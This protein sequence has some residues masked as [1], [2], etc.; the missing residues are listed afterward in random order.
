[1][2]SLYAGLGR[3]SKPPG[4]VTG[5]IPRPDHPVPDGAPGFSRIPLLGIYSAAMD[6]VGSPAATSARRR[7][8]RLLFLLTVLAVGLLVVGIGSLGYAFF[9]IRG[10]AALP[11]PGATPW[12]GLDPARIVAGPAL[13]TLAGRDP[14]Q[15]YRLTLAAGE[16]D[17]A[18]AEAI[19]AAAMADGQRI[20]WLTVLARRYALTGRRQQAAM[21]YQL[22]GDLALLAPNLGDRARVEALLAV[23]EGWILLQEPTRGREMLAQALLLTQSGL[24]LEPSVRGHLLE[25]AAHLYEKMG[26]P[27]AARLTRSLPADRPAQPFTPLPDPLDALQEAGPLPYPDTLTRAL[28]ARQAAAEAF[29]AAWNERGAQVAPGALAALGDALINEDLLRSAYYTARLGDG[30]LSPFEQA[31]TAWDQ[32]Q[33]LAFKHRAAADG[34]GV[35]LVTNWK[36]EL[37]AIRT[38][39][40]EAFA[41]TLTLTRA[42]VQTLPAAQ[43]GPAMYHLYAHGL[44]WARL[45]LYPDADTVFLANALNDALVAWQ[46]VAGP[47]TVAVIGQDNTVRFQLL[48]TKP[49]AAP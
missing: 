14:A 44:I 17:T 46:G 23:A 1:M 35:T 36:A 32:A 13:A 29:L 5:R 15:L 11:P 47:L 24:Y 31:R 12:D 6:T 33:W 21:L 42:Y 43:R 7:I 3:A 49:A 4:R 30:S 45:G 9:L 20:G 19:T 2:V 38:L 27:V 25:D 28:A 37:P 48:E 39:T 41:Q 26:D 18:A 16:L 22:T 8:R 10:Q 40:R 34:Y